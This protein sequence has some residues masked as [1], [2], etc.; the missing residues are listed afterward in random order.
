MHPLKKM[1]P[2][3]PHLKWVKQCVLII[4][5]ASVCLCLWVFVCVSVFL[6]LLIFR[7]TSGANLQTWKQWALATQNQSYYYRRPRRS[8]GQGDGGNKP[9]DY[10]HDYPR[11]CAPMYE[12]PY[13][14]PWPI[15]FR[16]LKCLPHSRIFH[17]DACSSPRHPYTTISNL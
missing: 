4:L 7:N 5:M 1:P 15:L 12:L 6:W 14:T 3:H 8:R 10:N 16:F 9:L 13:P 2:L 17:T 11:R